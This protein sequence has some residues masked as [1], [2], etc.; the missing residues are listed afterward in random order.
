MV[1]LL[2]PFSSDPVLSESEP[3]LSPSTLR[4]TEPPQIDESPASFSLFL[5]RDLSACLNGSE[6]TH[7]S[8]AMLAGS[9]ARLG[10]V[11]TP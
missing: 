6:Q 2:F 8:A 10:S 1:L 3:A 4:R 5:R 7:Q 9:S 11:Q